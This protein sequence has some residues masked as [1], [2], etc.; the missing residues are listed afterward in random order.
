MRVLTFRQAV[1]P[2]AEVEMRGVPTNGTVSAPALGELGV[3]DISRVEERLRAQGYCPGSLKPVTRTRQVRMYSDD[4]CIDIG[5][6]D[7]LA[8]YEGHIHDHVIERDYWNRVI[9]AAL[10]GARSCSRQMKTET[11]TVHEWRCD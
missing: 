4:Q 1:G 2:R 3:I 6:R 7:A 5:I 8:Q 9:D 10:E 11:Y